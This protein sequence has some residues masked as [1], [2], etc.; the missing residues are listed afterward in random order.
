MK[1]ADPQLSPESRVQKGTE[2]GVNMGGRVVSFA[3]I[4]VERAPVVVRIAEIVW[5]VTIFGLNELCCATEGEGGFIEAWRA[6]MCLEIGSEE[7]EKFCI[8]RR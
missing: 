4:A 2:R 1:L 3:S 5:G 8:A 6:A 7:F